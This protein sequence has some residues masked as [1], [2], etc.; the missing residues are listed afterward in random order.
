MAAVTAGWFPDPAGSGQLRYFDGRSWTNHFTPP[1]QAQPPP[2]PAGWYPDPGDPKAL[3]Y[4]D[5][6]QWT[7][8]RALFVDDA[9][10]APAPAT[11][12]ERVPASP[13]DDF[14]P[15]VVVSEKP[16][17]WTRE[18]LEAYGFRGFETFAALPAADVPR[19]PG[20]YCVLRD[21]T[22]P[23]VFLQQSPAGHF[24][25]EDPTVSIADLQSQWV[26]GAQ[27]IY[28]G[29]ANLG[30]SGTRGLRKRLDEFRAFGAGHPVGHRG[31]KRI[32]QLAD[33]SHLLV[34]WKT[35]A[36]GAAVPTEL[37]LLA[38]FRQAYGRLPFANMRE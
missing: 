13:A 3:R 19:A 17:S 15:A 20:V 26:D 35:T 34:A 9:P 37:E 27:V 7:A 30:A 10:A 32:W 21:S 29:K 16:L 4:W 25:G 36:D 11:E 31:G 12:I 2:V 33:S 24:K 8:Q 14:P 23:P 28:I 38:A 6:R 5:G 1:A 22:A 18:G